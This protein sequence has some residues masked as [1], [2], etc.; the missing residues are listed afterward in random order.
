MRP[1]WTTQHDP[2]NDEVT[3]TWRNNV[4]GVGKGVVLKIV[5]HRLGHLSIVGPSSGM[6]SSQ[7]LR[8]D[9]MQ[10]ALIEAGHMVVALDLDLQKKH[11]TLADLVAKYP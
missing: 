1:D 9:V 5:K 3:Y 4:E 8:A 10:R 7:P 2:H 6:F 11:V